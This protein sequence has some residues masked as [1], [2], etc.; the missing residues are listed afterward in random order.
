MC[1]KPLAALFYRTYEDTKKKKNCSN[2][3]SRAHV[4]IL[5]RWLSLAVRRH[6]YINGCG[7]STTPLGR[8]QLKAQR[9]RGEDFSDYA[10]IF[11]LLVLSTS[12]KR[13]M[14]RVHREDFFI[15]TK[16]PQ[17]KN[18]ERWKLKTDCKS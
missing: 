1:C 7:M 11:F 10:E 2:G 8:P 16:Q 9:L 13:S 6:R 15:Q 18:S 4:E 12:R 14:F 5:F 17:S 3:D